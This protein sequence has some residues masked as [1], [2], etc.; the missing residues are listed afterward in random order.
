MCSRVLLTGFFLL[1]LV[2]ITASADSDSAI[3]K[4]CQ[5]ACAGDGLSCLNKCLATSREIANPSND[6]S[7][8]VGNGQ[9]VGDGELADSAA[10]QNLRDRVE[11]QEGEGFG[12]REGRLGR[13]R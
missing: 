6:G 11:D 13:R 7:V 4:Q 3:Y 12:A 10:A 5:D 8:A 9:A 1:A 2:P